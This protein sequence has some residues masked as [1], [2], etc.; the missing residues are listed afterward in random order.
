MEGERRY[1][2]VEDVDGRLWRVLWVGPLY[3]CIRINGTLLKAC[4]QE[5]MDRAQALWWIFRHSVAFDFDPP[6][7]SAIRSLGRVH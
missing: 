5:G 1:P 2:M 7:A 3:Q 6:A 4:E